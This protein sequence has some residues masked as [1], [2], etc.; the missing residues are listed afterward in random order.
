MSYTILIAGAGQL[1]SRHLQG[2]TK[3]PLA[4]EIHVFDPSCASL[5]SAKTSI[6]Q[7]LNCD[8]TYSYIQDL[9]HLPATIDLCIVATCADVRYTVVQQIT[10]RANVRAWLLEKVL[11]QSSDQ[12]DL[13]RSCISMQPAWVNTPRRTYHL[14]QS[15][16]RRLSKTPLT[17]SVENISGLACN[18]IHYIDL[19][20]Y[21][22]GSTPLSAELTGPLTWFPSKRQRFQECFGEMHITFSNGS[23]LELSSHPLTHTK[24]LEISILE[25]DTQ[26]VWCSKELQRRVDSTTG[27]FIKDETNW[28]QS[29]LTAD[30]A[31]DVLKHQ[32]SLLPDLSTSITQHKV[33]FEPLGESLR[34]LYPKLTELPIT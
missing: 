6:L 22:S 15:L 30:L 3:L 20:Q 11:A 5:E 10:E 27:A 32:H 16:H 4:C 33:L 18:A 23:T 14:Y 7:C 8:H 9:S 1:G 12:L 13:I 28:Y 34:L 31:H 19:A 17:I 2:L 29:N 21:L 25:R 24:P 26:N